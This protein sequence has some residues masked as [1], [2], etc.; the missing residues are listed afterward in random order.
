MEGKQSFKISFLT[1]SK[2]LHVYPVCQLSIGGNRQTGMSPLKAPFIVDISFHETIVG[3]LTDSGTQFGIDC[4][5]KNGCSQVFDGRKA[6]CTYWDS[7][8][9]CY[10][11]QFYLQFTE[12]PI[13][14]DHS[15]HKFQA[16]GSIIVNTQDKWMGKYNVVGLN[17]E[18]KLMTYLDLG[19]EFKSEL[20]APKNLVE[21]SL[22]YGM[23]EKGDFHKRK[24]NL[25]DGELNNSWLTF[26]GRQHDKLQTFKLAVGIKTINTAWLAENL[27]FSNVEEDIQKNRHGKIVTCFTNVLPKYLGLQNHEKLIKKIMMQLCGKEKDCMYYNSDIS[28][29]EPLKLSIQGTETPH[30]IILQPIEFLRLQKD[31]VVV[32]I[33]GIDTF[34]SHCPSVTSLRFGAFFFIARE[35]TFKKVKEKEEFE[36]WYTPVEMPLQTIFKEKDSFASQSLVIVLYLLGYLITGGYIF[37]FSCL[38]DQYKFVSEKRVKDSNKYKPYT[39][40]QGSDKDKNEANSDLGG[41]GDGSAKGD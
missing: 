28:K 4:Q 3:E 38:P 7:L 31:L 19:Y 25:L 34:E 29:V 41:W 15:L 24:W 35:L 27:R 39:F 17:P 16:L 6:P 21:F 9:L 40:E 11:A 20:K 23:I 10:Q 36:M 26:N 8:G 2:R 12:V 14:I 32:M 18:S 5:I 13:Q 1:D 33:D 37:Y 22:F 30:E